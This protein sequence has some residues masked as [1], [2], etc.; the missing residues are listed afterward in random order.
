MI[1]LL[2]IFMVTA[3]IIAGAPVR[4]PTAVH[5]T[6]HKGETLNVV[7]RADGAS[8]D[9]GIAARQTPLRSPTTSRHGPRRRG[10]C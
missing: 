3:P 4:L 8:H 1:V 7:V 5:P 9:R 10:R 6:E 2:I